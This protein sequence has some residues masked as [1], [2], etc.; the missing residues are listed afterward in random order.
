MASV[1]AHVILCASSTTTLNRVKQ[2][3]IYFTPA[4][5]CRGYFGSQ[6]QQLLQQLLEEDLIASTWRA[7]RSNFRGHSLTL[8]AKLALRVLRSAERTRGVCVG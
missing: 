6:G 4:C 8:Y 3:I 2:R 1:A 5:S 7:L